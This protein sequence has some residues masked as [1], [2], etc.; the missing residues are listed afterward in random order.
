MDVLGTTKS[1]YVCLRDSLACRLI[2][3]SQYVSSVC[4]IIPEH[5]RT[6]YNLNQ[7]DERTTKIDY[8]GGS[9]RQRT[10]LEPVHLVDSMMLGADERVPTRSQRL[11]NGPSGVTPPQLDQVDWLK[12]GRELKSLRHSPERRL[13]GFG[14]R[15]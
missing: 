7:L 6:S 10:R 1:V 5:T 13:Y 14:R 12:R 11:V 15:N 4:R 9:R 3:S 2:W 8:I